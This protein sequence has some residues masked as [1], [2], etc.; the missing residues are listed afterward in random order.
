M[1]FLSLMAG[2][3]AASHWL[4]AFPVEAGSNK[5]VKERIMSAMIE[6]AGRPL[7]GA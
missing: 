5:S 7:A 6:V 2:Y 4:C 1:F 3:L